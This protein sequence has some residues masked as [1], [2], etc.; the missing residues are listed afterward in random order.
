MATIKLIGRTTDFKGKTLWEIVGNLRNHGVGRLV[1]RNMFQRYPEPSFMKIVKVEAL[2]N[3]TEVIFNVFLLNLF[4]LIVLNSSLAQQGDRKVKVF[5]E[6]TFRGTT[7]P[8]LVE[9]CSTSYKADYLL[10]PKHQEEALLN[11]P[12]AKVERILPQTMEFPALLREFIVRETGQQNP[13]LPVRIKANREKIARIAA[14]GEVPNVALTM[15]L[16]KPI[17]PRLYKGLNV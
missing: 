2:P 9:I 1:Q 11:S 13:Q 6:K 15:G 17:S 16:G 5:V 3:P 7:C 8:R 10:V 14:D 4:N 12:P